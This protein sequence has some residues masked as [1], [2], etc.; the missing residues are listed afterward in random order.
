[1]LKEAL[2]L[3]AQN[4]YYIPIHH[5]MRPWV[6][7]KNVSMVHRSD[8]RPESRFVTISPDE[9]AGTSRP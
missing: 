2:H 3:T 8:D 7:K 4:Y 1:M 5:Q 6:M 9:R